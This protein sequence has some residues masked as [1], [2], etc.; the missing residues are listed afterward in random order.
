MSLFKLT[1]ISSNIIKNKI[2]KRFITYYTDSHGWV[3]LIDDNKNA[4][5]GITEYAQRE[6]EQLIATAKLAVHKKEVEKYPELMKQ[7]EKDEKR[8]E[9]EKKNRDILKQKQFQQR[10]TT[11]RTK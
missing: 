4:I 1:R 9:Q 10:T 7:F 3:K 8:L 2:K 11:T 6:L 5:I